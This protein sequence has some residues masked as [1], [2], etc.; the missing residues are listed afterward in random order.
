MRIQHHCIKGLSRLAKLARQ[1]C[2]L[3]FFKQ[4][5]VLI[6][7]VVKS[8]L[9]L[10]QLNMFSQHFN[11]S[12]MF[13]LAQFSH[14][15]TTGMCSLKKDN[16]LKIKKNYFIPLRF[17]VGASVVHGLDLLPQL[18]AL[19]YTPSSTLFYQL[20][21]LTSFSDPPSSVNPLLSLTSS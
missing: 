2:L 17:L 16:Y 7:I 1:L 5:Q 13:S 4:M 20:L 15:V 21:L 19:H 14:T 11:F 12:M 3:S 8:I 9:H 18:C 6:C 10:K